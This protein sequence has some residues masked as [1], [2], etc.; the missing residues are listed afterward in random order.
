MRRILTVFGIA[1][2]ALLVATGPVAG[3]AVSPMPIQEEPAQEEPVVEAVTPDQLPAPVS[4][5]VAARMPG[6]VISSAEREIYTDGRVIYEVIGRVEGQLWDIE[7]TPEGEI[8]E[9]EEEDEEEE[10]EG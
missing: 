6:F 4:A 3:N 2:G 5:A 1:I 7:L 8:L 9:V 10:D